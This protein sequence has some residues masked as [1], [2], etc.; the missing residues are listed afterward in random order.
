LGPTN[1]ISLEDGFFYSFRII[2]QRKQISDDTLKLAVMKTSAPPVSVSLTAQTPSN[3]TSD[4]SVVVSIATN[5]PK[6]MEERIYLRWSTDFFITSHMVE[7]IGSGLNYSAIIPAQPGGTGV[8]YCL[9]T[10][11]GLSGSATDDGLPNPPGALTYVWSKVTGPESVTFGNAQILNTTATFSVGGIYTLKLSA[12]DSALTG[13]DTIILTVNKAPVVNAGP[14]QTITLPDSAPLSGSATDDDIPRPPGALTYTWS[15]V[16]G[17]GT[18]TFGN[19]HA[20]TTTT[21]FSASGTY[22]LKLTASDSVF[23]GTDTVLVTV[24]PSTSPTA[25]LKVTV[26]DGKSTIV[27]GS[28]NTYTI[29]VTNAGPVAVTGASVI[30]TFP[31]IFTGV[32]F[33]AT[34]SGGAT[35]FAASGTGNINNTVDMPSGSNITYSAKGKL[36]SA[37]TGNLS[38]TAQV[39]AP[40]G[41]LDPST[42]NNSATDSDSITSQADLKVTITDTKTAAVA[43]T[44][45][46]YTIVVTNAGSSDVA[47]A[48][49]GDTFPT[50]FTGVTFTASQTGGATGFTAAGSGDITDTVTMP[51]NSKIT[52]K[53]S[54]TIAGSAS[55][56][57]SDTVTVTSPNNVKDPNTANNSATDTDSL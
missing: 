54:G 43:G 52:Y 15:K 45:N 18:V 48:V 38:N 31:S 27:A 32:T 9:A 7:A 42:A 6:P 33:T 2:N 20:A 57:I 53:A 55:G 51:A 46:T 25:D 44:K 50:I 29:T 35:G 1:S 37:A 14:D 39:T 26:S 13:T 10:S 47:G 22:S 3:P 28:Q 17:P 36:S 21:S 12:S 5:Q 11:T 34:Q 4:D 30:D 19:V 24:N 49:I 56:S 16:S 40:S 23:T 8:Q 41:V